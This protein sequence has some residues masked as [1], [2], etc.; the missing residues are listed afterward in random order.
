MKPGNSG[1]AKGPQFKDQR[2]RSKAKMIGDEPTNSTPLQKLRTALHAKAKSEPNFRFYALYDKVYR[3][4]VLQAAWE[5]SRDNDGVPGV[6]G[7]TFADIEAY[8]VERWL[9]ELA[10]ELR[11]KRYEPQAVRREFIPKPDGNQRPLGIPTIRDRVVQT[12]LLL[13]LEPIFEADLQPEQYAYR[14]GRSALDAVQE[15]ER[16][17]RAGYRQVVDA[18]LSG[19][20]DTIPHAELVNCVARRVSDKAV[21]HLVKQWLVAAVEET[22]ER[23]C[24]Q[25]TT[26]NKDSGRGTPQGAPISPLLANLYMR[27]FVL[28]WKTLGHERR[29]Q[30]RIVNYADD[31][32]ILCRGSADDALT[33]MRSMMERLK[34]T[35]NETKTHVCRL[36][37]QSFDFLSY[38]FG[39]M[40]SPRTG[41]AYLGARPAK[42]QVQEFCHAI[43]D[44]VH[45]L[46]TFIRPEAVVD[47]VN[48]KVRGWAAYFS[49]GTIT[50]ARHIV[51]RH[52]MHR[53]RRW[54]RRKFQLPGLGTRQFSD[55][56]IEHTLGLLN[57]LK[58]PRRSFSWAKT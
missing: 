33:T 18:D 16:L 38:T 27:R 1:G 21:L 42:K 52:V 37:E 4:D 47:Q 23:G 6:N 13:I 35:V 30:A 22:D 26:R 14:E 50:P 24:V 5:R 31:F 57:P 36:P 20:F 48:R 7:Q 25:R 43:N 49:Y 32:V 29:L 39:R 8:G 10:E 56:H 41:G 3:P 40:N 19:Y 53:V 28:G 44:L 9:G 58:L 46:P 55:E 54:L 11:T 15:V 34:L 2:E 45:G 17:V 12:A 51:H